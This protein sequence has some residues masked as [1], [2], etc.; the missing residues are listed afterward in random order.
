MTDK[1]GKTILDDLQ[2]LIDFLG[3][4]PEL[5]L[6]ANFALSVYTFA[7]ENLETARGIAKSLGTFDKEL[8]NSMFSLV[9]HFGDISLRFVFYRDNV[10]IKR[11]VGTKTETIQVPAADAPDVLMV[12]K[13][14]ETEIVEWDCPSL[15]ANDEATP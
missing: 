14:V 13:V 4:H 1:Y 11:V 2:S 8:N 9:K 6:P 7:N 12:D 10:C 15:L 5:P 3:A